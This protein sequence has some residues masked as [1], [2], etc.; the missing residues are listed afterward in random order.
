[1]DLD[2]T[3]N[4]DCYKEAEQLKKRHAKF[5]ALISTV[6]IEKFVRILQETM[7]GK[8]ERISTFNVLQKLQRQ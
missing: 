6:R 3:K 2:L 4:S 7:K 1:M 8:K 5:L